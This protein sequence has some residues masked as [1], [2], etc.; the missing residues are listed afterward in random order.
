MSRLSPLPA[1]V[2][3][4]ERFLCPSCVV[5]IISPIPFRIV[6]SVIH[7]CFFKFRAI[8]L[9]AR[10]FVDKGVQGANASMLENHDIHPMTIVCIAPLRGGP[11]FMRSS[12]GIKKNVGGTVNRIQT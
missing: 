1:P 5:V 10:S 12:R 9:I 2:I 6:F 4:A 8:P 11:A 7:G 3:T